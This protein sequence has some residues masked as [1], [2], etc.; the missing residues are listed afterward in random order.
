MQ[1]SLNGLVCAED[2]DESSGR[3]GGV[4]VVGL[5]LLLRKVCRDSG[6][7]ERE[8]FGVVPKES[9]SVW[10]CENWAC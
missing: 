5:M 2:R 4:E 7:F 3:V 6:R 8:G 9:Q 1:H 10:S